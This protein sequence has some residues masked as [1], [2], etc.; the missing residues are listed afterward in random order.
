MENLRNID[1]LEYRQ[2][3]AKKLTDDNL[4][5]EKDIEYYNDNQLD[6]DPNIKLKVKGKKKIERIKKGVLCAKSAKSAK[7]PN[8]K[9]T[10]GRDPNNNNLAFLESQYRRMLDIERSLPSYICENL[11]TLPNNRGYIWRGMWCFGNL[12]PTSDVLY[13]TEPKKGF[14]LMHELT[15]THYLIR[16]KKGR[17]QPVLVSCVQR[18]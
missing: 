6:K 2:A 14:V 4:R 5:L 15:R 12:N 10:I 11:K 7:S 16:S 9:P 1:D 8:K 17:E 3:Q 18:V 13:L